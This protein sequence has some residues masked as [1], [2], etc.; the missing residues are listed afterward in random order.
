MPSARRYIKNLIH[1]ALPTDGPYA[2]DLIAPV[3]MKLGKPISSQK[4]FNYLHV[5]HE[6]NEVRREPEMRGSSVIRHKWYTNRV[7]V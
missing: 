5:M 4:I 1:E 2:K 6:A 3:S 7:I